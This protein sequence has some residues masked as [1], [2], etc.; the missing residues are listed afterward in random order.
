MSKLLLFTDGAARGNPGPAGTGIVLSQPD[1]SVVRELA[2][3]IGQTTNN[4]AEYVALIKGLEEALRLGATE[5]EIHTDSE[6]VARQIAGVYRVRAEHL[7]PLVAQVR[8]LLAQFRQVEISHIVRAENRIA[9]ALAKKA[10][11]AV[12]SASLSSKDISS[13]TVC[14]E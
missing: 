8:N 4:V 13:K 9:D 11:R 10:A 12:A 7:V 6:L 14:A 1:G 2:E 3:Y 5:I